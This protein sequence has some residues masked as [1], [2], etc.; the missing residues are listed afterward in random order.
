MPATRMMAGGSGWLAAAATLQVFE[1]SADDSGLYD[2]SG[3][4]QKWLSCQLR[5]VRVRKGQV[6]FL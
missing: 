3:A 1:N 2:V 6:R 4:T 5:T